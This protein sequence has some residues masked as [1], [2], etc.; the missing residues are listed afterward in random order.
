MNRLASSCRRG[1]DHEPDATRKQVG[2]ANNKSGA[3]DALLHNN[4]ASQCPWMSK[5]T[6]E[7]D[8]AHMPRCNA[9]KARAIFLEP[10]SP[11]RKMTDDI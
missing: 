4:E 2:A 5:S 7:L 1:W 6:A 3:I 9:K 11:K 10:R 8:V